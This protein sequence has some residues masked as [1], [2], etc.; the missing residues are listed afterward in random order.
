[1]LQPLF[2]GLLEDAFVQIHLL[3]A[4][5]AMQSAVWGSVSCPMAPQHAD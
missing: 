2:R 3:M 4:L 5:A 1:M